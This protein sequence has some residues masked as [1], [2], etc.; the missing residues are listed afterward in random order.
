MLLQGSRARRSEDQ[1]AREDRAADVPRRQDR[2]RP[3]EPGASGAGRQ[4]P[5]RSQR[6]HQ[7]R[8][9]RCSSTSCAPAASRCARSCAPAAPIV[10]GIE[11]K[12]QQV[13]LNLFLNARDAMPKGGWLTI[14]TRA[15]GG[16]RDGRSRRYRLGHSR[17]AAVAHLRSVLH[18]QGDRQG[19]RP[20]PVDHLR[21]RPGAR[22]HDHLRQRV[23]QGTRFTLDAAARL[24]CTPRRERRPR[25]TRRSVCRQSVHC[26]MN[27]ERLHPRHRRRGDHAR[28]PRGAADARG[29]R[30][31]P[32]RRR[33]RG[34]RAGPH[35]AVRRRDRR[36]DDA[37]HGRHLGARR[38]RR[39]STTTCR[40]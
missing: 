19:H 2:Q 39:R 13:F 24:A 32:R 27:T 36:H 33:R 11:Y 6:R 10:Q 26:R 35:D 29:L 40:C 17:R 8:A 9:R 23:G 15:D 25:S 5:G 1:G 34:A 12:L 20:R 7:R 14:V 3:A 31:A 4:R 37:G 28:D 30:G 38:A 22:R 16:R 18:H 21:H